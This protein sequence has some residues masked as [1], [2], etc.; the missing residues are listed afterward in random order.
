MIENELRYLFLAFKGFLT[1]HYL[2]L[3]R[4]RKKDEV[5]IRGWLNRV[6]S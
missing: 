2:Q 1:W 3:V 4:K 6:E 5:F